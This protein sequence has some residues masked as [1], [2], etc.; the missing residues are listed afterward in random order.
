MKIGWRSYE[1][2]KTSGESNTAGGIAMAWRQQSSVKAKSQWRI[3]GSNI[4]GKRQA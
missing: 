3:N 1:R 2:K 4:N